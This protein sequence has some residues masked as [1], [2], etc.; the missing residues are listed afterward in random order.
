MLTAIHWLTLCVRVCSAWS[1]DTGRCASSTCTCALAVMRVA[2]HA[3]RA[4]A[5]C[6]RITRRDDGVCRCRSGAC[7]RLL[8]HAAAAVDGRC[9]MDWVVGIE[10]ACVIRRSNSSS[11]CC[12]RR[13]QRRAQQRTHMACRGC[14]R[15]QRRQ[16]PHR[17]LCA[18]LRLL[19]LLLAV[20]CRRQSSLQRL[21]RRFRRR[22]RRRRARRRQ[23]RARQ[24]ASSVRSGSA[25]RRWPNAS[26]SSRVRAVVL[27]AMRSELTR[28][29]RRVPSLHQ[30][31]ARVRCAC[32]CP[33]AAHRRRVMERY[34]ARCGCALLSVTR[35][36][37]FSSLCAHRAARKAVWYAPRL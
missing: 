32:V 9:S 36:D 3:L 34:G 29:Q 12:F 10:C 19:R 2:V 35:C 18:R 25:G 5:S 33:S 20:L 8:R 13:R 37:L 30:Q 6:A 22:R 14:R 28:S 23:Q 21:Q 15:A 7:G 26:N 31:R 24:R 17:R 11:C 1:A 27:F 4:D 16:H